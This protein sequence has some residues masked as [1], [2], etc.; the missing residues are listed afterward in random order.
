MFN[1]TGPWYSPKCD[2]NYNPPKCTDYFHTQMDTPNLPG[3]GGYGE[4]APPACNCGSKPCGFY[5]F[6]HSSD[7]VIR[8]VSF[9]QG[10][11]D[12]Y[13]FSA[14]GSSPAVSGFFWGEGRRAFSRK[15]LCAIR[16]VLTPSR[17]AFAR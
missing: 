15:A 6:N 1:S 3:R 2:T 5:V 17:C 12:S 9:Q 10:F 11:I 8:G 16:A 14:V 13:M 4:C 7:A